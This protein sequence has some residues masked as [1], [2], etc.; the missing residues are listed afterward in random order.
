MAGYSPGCWDGIVHMNLSGGKRLVTVLVSCAMA[1]ALL[2]VSA[3]MLLGDNS[4]SISAVQILPSAESEGDTAGA[5]AGGSV[6]DTGG[7]NPVEPALIAIYITGEVVNPGVY[8]MEAGKRL[9]HAVA[10]A[11]GPTGNADL[12]RVNMAEYLTDA[13]KY[14]IPGSSG[15]AS[16][17][18]AP[19]GAQPGN[20][21]L[22]APA[23]TCG[24]PVNINTATAMCLETL[25]GIGAVRARE[26]VAHRNQIGTFG[27][28]HGIMDVAGIGDGI[29]GRIAGMIAVSSP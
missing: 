28:T 19:H 17:S 29:Y 23:P 18:A 4:P 27:S 11:G 14:Q 8:E 13:A 16:V 22:L 6:T 21:E 15:D 2:I 25:P 9:N 10:V 24:N 5:V 3:W 7:A 26:I 12:N 20:A 1:V